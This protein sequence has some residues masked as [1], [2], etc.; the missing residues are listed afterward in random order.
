MVLTRS[1]RRGEMELTRHTGF[2]AISHTLN[3]VDRDRWRQAH[4]LRS[5]VRNIPISPKE[6]VFR[7]LHQ[8]AKGAGVHMELWDTRHIGWHEPQ[9]KIS[10]RRDRS[11]S[12]FWVGYMS[13]Y[14]FDSMYRAAN[15]LTLQQTINFVDK[16]PFPFSRMEI[17]RDLY[18]STRNSRVLGPYMWSTGK[19]NN[20]HVIWDLESNAASGYNSENGSYDST[21]GIIIN[22]LA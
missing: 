4:P 7:A 1:N 2:N 18:S 21:G 22:Y 17:A 11:P 16:W 15:G 5:Y 6:R 19:T 3:N 14:R 8:L 12:V 20:E 10:V 9:I 13:G